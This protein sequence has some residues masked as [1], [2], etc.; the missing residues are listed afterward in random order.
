MFSLP[1]FMPVDEL[2]ALLARIIDEN[3]PALVA[4]RAER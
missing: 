3:E 4:A 1:G 2:I